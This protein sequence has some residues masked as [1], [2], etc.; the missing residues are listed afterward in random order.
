M[1]PLSEQ[2]RVAEGPRDAGGRAGSVFRLGKG[3]W[4]CT[5]A[6]LMAGLPR[7]SWDSGPQSRERLGAAWVPRADPARPVRGGR[8][9]RGGQ[10]GGHSPECQVVAGGPGLF[11]PHQVPERAGAAPLHALLLG[12]L[13]P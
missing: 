7:K 8:R 5:Q 10:A 3:N 1:P 13:P 2:V 9:R 12:I 11:C 4:R 6:A